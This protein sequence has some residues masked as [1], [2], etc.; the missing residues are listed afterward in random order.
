LELYALTKKESN[1]SYRII[2]GSLSIEHH[3]LLQQLTFRKKSKDG[4]EKTYYSYFIK[5]PRAVYNL[6][7][8][9]DDLVYL[10]QDDDSLIELLHEPTDNS[11]KVKIQLD[12]KSLTDDTSEYR[13]KLTIPKK[14]I[15]ND[16]FIRG[17]TYIILT[18]TS[19]NNKYG[20][21]ITLRQD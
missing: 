20:Y 8:P 5:L 4:T 11:R 7:E 9:T 17:Q 16:S 10:K 18:V 15:E 12:N 3:I 19:K 2:E 1:V 14:F 6:L 21:Y 13:Y